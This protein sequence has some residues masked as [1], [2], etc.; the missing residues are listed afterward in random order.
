MIRDLIIYTPMYV[1]FFWALVLLLSK[2]ENNPAKFFLGIFMSVAFLV[3]IS[4]TVF[5]QQNLHAYQFFDPIYVFSSLAVYP[6]YYWYIKLLT[7]ET[8]YK[9]TNLLY[10]LPAVVLA[11]ATLV[12]Y[13]F[14]SDEEKLIYIREFL[15][16]RSGSLEDSTAI[17]IQKLIFYFSR[18][19]FVVQVVL[20][21]IFGRKLV[22]RYN[23]RVANFYSNLDSKTIFWVK[24]LLYSYVATSIMSIVANLI[25][26]NYFAES[27]ILLLIPSIIFST[28]LFFIGLLG[29][30]QN[31]TVVDL[32]KDENLQPAV[33]QKKL[34][35]SQLQ[36]KLL[37]LF[38]K[39]K[40]YRKPELKITEVSQLLGT[41][42]SYVSALINTEFSCSFNEFVN[43]YR[44]AEAKI[45][46]KENSNENYSLNYIAESA[47]FGSVGTFIRVFKEMEGTT[48]GKY[49]EAKT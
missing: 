16:D 49:R 13:Q 25:G 28:L 31:H 36:N 43:K 37:E 44:I 42:R 17:K 20:F 29:Y 10:L 32:V 18:I 7:I 46:I 23:K 39:E 12:A 1:T 8:S 33:D 3:Y 6:L 34:N 11:L 45:L 15:L 9:P 21:L 19:V 41:N 22:L 35:S 38:E 40:A 27:L 4:H 24:Y 47:G 26:R 30:M 14:M 2:K 5:F 48:P